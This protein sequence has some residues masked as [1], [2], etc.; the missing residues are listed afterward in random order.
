[1]K[2]DRSR[3]LVLENVIKL[4]RS[5]EKKFKEGNFKEAIFDK[6]EA[7]LIIQSI[8]DDEEIFDKFKEE[9]S[10]LYSSKFD[11][12]FDHKLKIN[13]FKRIEIIRFLER[14]SEEKFNKGDYKGAI[15]ALRRSEHYLS[16]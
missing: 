12:I 10:D 16:K 5:S 13:E 2:N 6:R 7:K 15:K 11:L 3:E 1:M 4:T 14:K 8:S 9:L